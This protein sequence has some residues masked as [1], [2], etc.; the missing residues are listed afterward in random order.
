[1]CKLVLA[2]LLNMTKL[3]KWASAFILIVVFTQK[4]NAQTYINETAKWTQSFSYSGFGNSTYCIYTK[5][6]NGDSTYNNKVYYKLYSQDFCILTKT[7]FDSLGNPYLEKDTTESLIFQGLVREENKR[8]YLMHSDSTEYLYYNYN[9]S[10]QTP[11]DSLV[12]NLGCGINP[13]ITLLNHDTVCIGNEGRKRWRISSSMY[14]L[15]FYLI[16]GVGPSSGFLA[17]ICRN[18]CPECGYSLLSFTLN[19]DTLYKGQCSI[20]TSVT[21]SHKIALDVYP[22]PT[23]DLLIVHSDVIINSVF[24]YDYTGRLLDKYN[25]SNTEYQLSTMNY[26][27]GN[28]LLEIRTLDS[29]FRKK[30]IKE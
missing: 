14:P 22:I 29:I 25:I 15:A 26:A 16:E 8:I 13:T 30:I 12:K 9:F 28:Y 7:L 24:V 3:T 21:P 5:Y 2:K 27:K 18:G 20:P 1:M 23:Q 6:F 10:N 17:P 11:V 4:L 19:G